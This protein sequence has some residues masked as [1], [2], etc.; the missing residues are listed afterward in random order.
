MRWERMLMGLLL[1]GLLSGCDVVRG[2]LFIATV[3]QY[4]G[5]SVP[6]DVR[7][8]RAPEQAPVRVPPRVPPKV[9]PEHE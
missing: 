1:A 3:S 5:E 2:G 8:E 7:V 9:S 4:H 6:G